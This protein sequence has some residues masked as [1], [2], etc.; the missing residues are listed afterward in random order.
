MVLLVAY[1]LRTPNDTPENY[2]LIIGAIKSEFGGWA[3]IEQSVW[4]VDS[5]DNASAVRDFLKGY[6]HPG[7]ALFVAALQKNWASW[8]FGNKRNEWLKERVF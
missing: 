2:E 8:N 7:D 5:E 6:L 3:H 1:D 4:L